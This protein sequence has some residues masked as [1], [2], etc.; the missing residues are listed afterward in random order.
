ML[1]DFYCPDCD[2][3]GVRH[4]VEGC[5]VEFARDAIPCND[6]DHPEFANPPCGE[7]VDA[8]TECDRCGME[9][10]PDMVYQQALEQCE[11]DRDHAY[12]VRCA[13]WAMR[14]WAY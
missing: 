7:S 10:T 6:P 4:I 9:I 5:E 13:R 12:E 3:D 8:P 2:E 11:A 1:V 14:R